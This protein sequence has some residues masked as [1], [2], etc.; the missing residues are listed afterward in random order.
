MP[1]W[2]LNQ[3]MLTYL[4]NP[5][6]DII[7][8]FKIKAPGSFKHSED[9]SILCEKI[10]R[11][12]KLN[13][14][15]CKILGLYHDIGKMLIPEF[16]SENQPK[17]TNVHDNL[18]PEISA[19]L[20]HSHVANSI[21]ILTTR[22]PN[23][24]LNIIKC[25]SMHHGD[26]CLKQFL[27]KLPEEL[28]ESKKIIFKYPYSKPDNVYACILM[29]CDI[30]EAKIRSLKSVNTEVDTEDIILKTFTSLSND[31]YLDELTIKQGRII[32]NTLINEY[33]TMDHKRVPYDNQEK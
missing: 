15:I 19:R 29:I 9:V 6:N 12:L 20:I 8:E 14:D 31:T 5:E 23:I 16:F 30:I 28:R 11:E 27:N 3:D 24:D 32:V 2:N 33:G 25:I 1:N 4:L 26:N 21:A 17:D 18:D 22:V 7:S 10:G 13:I